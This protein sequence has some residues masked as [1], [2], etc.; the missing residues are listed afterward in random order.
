M[1]RAPMMG[2]AKGS[3]HPTGA[4]ILPDGQITSCFPKWLVQPLLQ[5]YFPS[6]PTHFPEEIAEAARV[7]SWGKTGLNADI[8]EKMRLTRMYGP[9]VRCKRVR[10][11]GRCGLA[12][13][14]PASD[15]SVLCSGPSWISARIRA[16]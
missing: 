6:P 7:R 5:K 12:S 14:Y 15:W 16:D 1:L 4:Q 2:F 11:L 8:A 3:T 10:Q 13:M 9:A